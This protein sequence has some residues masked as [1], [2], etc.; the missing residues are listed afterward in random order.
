MKN[1]I[2]R[3]IFSLK[4]SPRAN[5]QNK[6]NKSVVFADSDYAL[7]QAGRR[8]LGHVDAGRQHLAGD[9]AECETRGERHAILCSEE[10]SDAAAGANG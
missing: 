3:F 4:R 2:D 5:K 1:Q 10:S 6:I 7:L 9:D 8:L